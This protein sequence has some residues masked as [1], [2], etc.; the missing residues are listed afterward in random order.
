MSVLEFIEINYILTCDSYKL[1]AHGRIWLVDVF[2]LTCTVFFECRKFFALIFSYLA[3]LENL[4]GE[5]WLAAPGTVC[6]IC[7][8]Q[9]QG[10]LRW[11]Q[12]LI[13]HPINAFI[14]SHYLS[15]LYL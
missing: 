12:P 2:G 6:Q 8:V 3:S 4:G 13:P 9:G 11:G 14:N 15:G 7:S 1:V 5:V 10:L